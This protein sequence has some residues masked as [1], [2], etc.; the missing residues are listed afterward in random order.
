[1]NIKT[2]IDQVLNGEHLSFDEINFAINLLTTILKDLKKREKIEN[3]IYQ[4]IKN[5]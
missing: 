5:L 1:M 4:F 2:I 3:P